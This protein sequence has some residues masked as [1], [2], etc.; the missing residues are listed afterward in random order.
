MSAILNSLNGHNLPIIQPILM[1]LASKFMVNRALSD[2]T[3][4][5]LGLLSPLRVNKCEF[6]VYTVRI[7]M[8]CTHVCAAQTTYLVFTKLE[9][10]FPCSADEIAKPRPDMNIKVAAF[11]VSEKS[12]NTCTS[13]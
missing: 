4:S 5:S 9:P 12:I 10:E 1:I 11:T 3:Y 8:K 2:I 6:S 13:D 7:Y